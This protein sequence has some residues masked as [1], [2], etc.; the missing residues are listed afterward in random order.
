MTVF[1]TADEK[2]LPVRAEAEFALGS[3]VLEAVRYE[4]GRQ[5]ARGPR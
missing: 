4:P 3:V 5:W 2:Q 1:Y